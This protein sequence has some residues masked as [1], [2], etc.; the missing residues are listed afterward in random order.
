MWV[1]PAKKRKRRSWAAESH[2]GVYYQDGEARDRSYP[3]DIVSTGD[4]THNAIWVLSN[5]AWIKSP[6]SSQA[7]FMIF[8][9]TNRWMSFVC[10]QLTR[11][12][13]LGRQ[14]VCSTQ[15][16][17]TMWSQW[18]TSCLKHILGNPTLSK[19]SESTNPRIS[20]FYARRMSV[21]DE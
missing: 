19:L 20:P 7:W 1:F 5:R 10:E 3:R 13:Y 8:W 12:N 9:R 15:D 4:K 11:I 17:P 16:R 2:S 18:Q 14:V 6:L 21:V